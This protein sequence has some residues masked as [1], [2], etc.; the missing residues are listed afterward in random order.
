MALR[1]PDH[2]RRAGREVGLIHPVNRAARRPLPPAAR[3]A[4]RARS[5]ACARSA[6]PARRPLHRR[7][8]RRRLRRRRRLHPRR[9]PAAGR[10]GGR[11]ERE[12][13]SQQSTTE[14]RNK[15]AALLA[16]ELK[17]SAHR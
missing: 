12:T 14:R 4:T 11:S 16:I 3:S 17:K 8:L 7:P 5:A 13:S 2:A 9:L 1:V 6:A 15:T 10:E